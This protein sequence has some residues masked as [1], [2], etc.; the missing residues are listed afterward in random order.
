MVYFGLRQ[1]E[2]E[3]MEMVKAQKILWYESKL[4]TPSALPQIKAGVEA[5]LFPDNKKTP[6]W[7]SF[8]IDGVC[9]TEFKSTGTPESVGIP[10][11]FMLRFFETFIPESV[12]MDFTEVNF[13]LSSGEQTEKDKRTVRTIIEKVTEVVHSVAPRY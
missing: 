3:E 1:W 9:H 8:D 4:C 2:P 6:Y 7:I 13:A 10:L 11:D 5:Y 12:G